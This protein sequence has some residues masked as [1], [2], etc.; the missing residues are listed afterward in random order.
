MIKLTDA[1]LKVMNVLWHDGDCPATHIAETLADT[2]GW[3][4]NTTYTIIHK[5]IEKGAIERINPKFHCHALVS[6]EEAQADM[7]EDLVNKLYDGSRNS[8]FAALLGKDTLSDEQIARLRE[9][10]AEME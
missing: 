9:I 10:V 3:H 4:A 5:C 6:Q 8:L 1:E 2:T 7:T